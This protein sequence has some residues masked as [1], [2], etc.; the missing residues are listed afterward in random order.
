MRTA[1]QAVMFKSEAAMEGY[2]IRILRSWSLERFKKMDTIGVQRFTTIVVQI[3]ENPMA[4]SLQYLQTC[5]RRS[6]VVGRSLGVA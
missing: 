6:V 5:V 2:G 4:T 3:G 1:S